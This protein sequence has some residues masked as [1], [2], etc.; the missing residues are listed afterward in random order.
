[1]TANAPP[2]LRSPLAGD[3]TFARAGHGA[4]PLVVLG[5]FRPPGITPKKK[6]AKT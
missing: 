6:G 1:M 4:K 2:T 5:V 3:R